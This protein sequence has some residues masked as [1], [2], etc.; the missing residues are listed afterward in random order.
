MAIIEVYGETIIDLD[1]ILGPCAD[2][3][4][5]RHDVQTYPK[6]HK[7]IGFLRN[8]GPDCLTNNKATKSAFHFGPSSVRQRNAI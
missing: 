1:L 2:P 4:G 8:T 5:G 6:N 3:E 7:N